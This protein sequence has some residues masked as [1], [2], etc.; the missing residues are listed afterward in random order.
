MRLGVLIL[1]GLLVAIPSGAQN[2]RD[3]LTADE[4]DQIRLVQEPNERLKLYMHFARQRM[5]QVEQLL[6]KDRAG[7][8]V[9]VHDLLEDYTQIIEAVDTVADDALRR[10]VDIAKGMEAVSAGEKELLA[11]LEKIQK[12]Q[13]K[14]I[15][16]FDFGLKDAIDTTTDS[17]ELSEQDI[18]ER[19]GAVAA[20]DKREQ[21]E[22]RAAMTPQELEEKKAEEKKAVQAKKKIPT[23]RRPDDPPP[24]TDPAPAKKR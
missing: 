3:F 2:R 4:A 7:R 11:K 13:P 10:K 21:E 18:G 19:A 9:L 1:S 14:D 17:A 6:N 23:L 20:K 15:A 5:D 12:A 22:R 16:R 24:S 8:S